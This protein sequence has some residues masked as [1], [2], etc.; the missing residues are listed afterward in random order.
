MNIAILLAQSALRSADR[1]AL[2]TG[3]RIVA[4]YAQL[5]RRSTQRAHALSELAERGERIALFMG[6]SPAFI[7]VLFATWIAG[8][9]AVPVNAKLHERELEF[10]LDHCGARICVTDAEHGDTAKAAAGATRA[11]TRVLSE[12]DTTAMRETALGVI[13]QSGNDPAWLFYTS[14][15]T[16]QPK[17]AIL[18]HRNLLVMTLNYFCDQDT[19]AEHDAI[20]HAA[21][22][23]HGSGLWAL[24]HIAKGALH[25]VPES[26]GFE[27]PEIVNL[28]R[29]Y[30]GV[31][32]FAA[33]TMVHRLVRHLEEHPA[34]LDGLKTISYGGGPM[35]E[36]DI[37][38]ALEIIGPKFVQLYGQ[39]ESPMTIT[40]LSRSD[41]A[42]VDQPRYR[43][44]LRSVGTVRTGCEVR[45]VHEDGTILAP[46]E[47]GEITVRGDVVM[48]GYWND[49]AATAATL[50][51]GWLYT[52]D[53]GAFDA[54]GYLTLMDRTKDVIISGG[55]NIYPREV[56][57][58]LAAQ[59]GVDQV[60][61]VGRPNADWGEEVV[62]FVVLAPEASVSADDLDRACLAAIA[63]FKR[64]KEYF[65]VHELPK[66]EY[67]KVLKREL[68]G[69]LS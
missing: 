56:E 11:G 55:S 59:S 52:G 54:D 43:E 15:T 26:G 3:E 18:T 40:G 20:I 25:I 13:E 53:A 65:F 60:A 63:R 24:P 31:T 42:A 62:A 17:G 64:P 4:T 49:A 66:N 45:I 10:I 23:S 5:Y 30:S 33:P 19:I 47:V 16:G 6:N 28:L 44:R 21:P 51:D 14:G 27:P 48:R 34:T 9:I 57:D 37:L 7:E 35:Y 8:C 32:L 46:G 50:R 41:H 1:P 39:G 12:S 68:R 36:A 38:R 69:R 58:I 61:V 2:A 29:V 22:M 67:G